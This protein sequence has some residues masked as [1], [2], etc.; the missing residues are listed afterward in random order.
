MT[1]SLN[2]IISTLHFMRCQGP[3]CLDIDWFITAPLNDFISTLHLMKCQGPTCVDIAIS[4]IIYIFNNYLSHYLIQQGK[5]KAY[6]FTQV[7]ERNDF[8]MSLSHKW[9]FQQFIDKQHV[10]FKGCYCSD[11]E[12]CHL[13]RRN[14]V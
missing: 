9:I 13:V 6:I 7:L 12:Y 14:T 1:S 11:Y 3:T 4:I 8:F 10:I 2:D 5:S